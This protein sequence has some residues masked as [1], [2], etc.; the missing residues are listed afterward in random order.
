[1]LWWRPSWDVAE[2]R[3]AVVSSQAAGFV[4]VRLA[5]ICLKDVFTPISVKIH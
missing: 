5:E 1:M 3:L 4:L 2:L